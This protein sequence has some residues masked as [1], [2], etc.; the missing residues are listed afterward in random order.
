MFLP[1]FATS[2]NRDDIFMALLSFYLH[3]QPVFFSRQHVH[4]YGKNS[5]ESALKLKI[6]KLRQTKN[7]I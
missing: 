6:E 5:G 2:T 1:L 3:L 7:C 4:F